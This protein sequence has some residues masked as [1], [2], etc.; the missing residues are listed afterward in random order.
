VIPTKLTLK[1]GPNATASASI[2]IENTGS[3]SEL[4]ER[5]SLDINLGRKMVR[6]YRTAISAL[7]AAACTLVLAMQTAAAE[8]ATTGRGLWVGGTVFFSEFQGKAL[9]QSGT[10]RAAIAFGSRAFFNPTSI[11]FDAHHNLW[12][13]FGGVV[14]NRPAPVVEISAA[15]IVALASGL[16]VKPQVIIDYPSNKPQAFVVPHSLGF[17]ASGDLWVADADVH[18]LAEFTRNQIVHSGS[19]P[20]NISIASQDFLP[21]VMRFDKSDNL[22]MAQF[23][24]PPSAQQVLKFVP[25]DR[26]A[27]GEPNPSLTIDLPDALKV[28][29]LGIDS[30]GNLWIA[31]GSSRGD[32]LEMFSA[33]DLAGSGEISPAAETMVT[34]SAFGVVF[35]GSC[36][37][38]ID[39]DHVGDLWVSVGTNND[40]CEAAQQVV[41]FT[42]GQ[43]AIGGNQTPTVT[44]GQ[45]K[46][47]TNL[48]VPGPIRFGPSP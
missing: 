40:E 5:I 10:P 2:T 23:S 47:K 43:L 13:G 44:I 35:G 34:S 33:S 36:L 41:E 48:F 29:D 17:D 11:V 31:G 16:A 12:A 22:W 38:G 37:G 30:A 39:F 9:K 45:N 7:L 24:V 14:G 21:N 20:A 1:V 3:D 19:P 6:T 32:A 8:P 42:P 15:D 18:G 27:S 26:A 25:G 28:A 46:K 4:N